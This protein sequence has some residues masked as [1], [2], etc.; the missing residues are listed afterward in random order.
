M[1]TDLLIVIILTVL[2]FYVVVKTNLSVTMKTTLI[3][4]TI[5]AALNFYFIGKTKQ[6]IERSI[7][8]Q[9][10]SRQLIVVPSWRDYGGEK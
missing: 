4:L 6:E 10:E 8:F 9:T 5:S 3:I 1:K 2:H 7:A